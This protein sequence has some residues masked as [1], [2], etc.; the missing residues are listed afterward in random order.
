MEVIPGV[1]HVDGTARVQTLANEENPLL[2]SVIEQ[3]GKLSGVPI[4]VNTSLNL[5]GEPVSCSP[6]DALSTFERSG[7]DLLVMG[8]WIVS[9]E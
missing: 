2:Y 5:R 7:M 9:K 8:Q 4:L 3:F 6:E 1:T